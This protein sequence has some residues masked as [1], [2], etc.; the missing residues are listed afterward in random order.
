VVWRRSRGVNSFQTETLPNEWE[1]LQREPKY[2]KIAGF[3]SHEG[4]SCN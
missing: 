2:E 1:G 4:R 3:H